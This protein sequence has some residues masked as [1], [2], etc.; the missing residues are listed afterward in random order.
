MRARGQWQLTELAVQG[1]GMGE[2]GRCALGRALRACRSTQL[3]HEKLLPEEEQVANKQNKKSGGGGGGS[4]ARSMRMN[5]R[6]S[7]GAVVAAQAAAAEAAK[8]RK[9]P[10]S[11]FKVNN[12]RDKAVREAIMAKSTDARVPNAD[13]SGGGGGGL[14]GEDEEDE[15]TDEDEEEYEDDDLDEDPS[16]RGSKFFFT[17]DG[18][19]VR[20]FVDPG[21]KV[22]EQAKGGLTT[23][24]DLSYP[25]SASIDGVGAAKT[26]TMATTAANTAAAATTKAIGATERR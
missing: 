8:G 24:V 26:A 1:N 3:G 18:L 25:S 7:S 12:E 11:V 21:G 13:G 6:R 4:S 14:G 10:Q 19:V 9:L 22:L 20:G 16:H 17:S 2:T 15:E 5:R 23:V